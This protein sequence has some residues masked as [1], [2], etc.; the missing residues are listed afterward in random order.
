M[1]FCFECKN[2]SYLN[3]IF[4]RAD[5]KFGI[6]LEYYLSNGVKMVTDEKTE[7]PGEEKE[8]GEPTGTRK[9]IRRTG[10]GADSKAV[11]GSKTPT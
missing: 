7:N 1:V 11:Q 5:K 6:E 10:Q 9:Y 8:V 2:I 3:V 4:F